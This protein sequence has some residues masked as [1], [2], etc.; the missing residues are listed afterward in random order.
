MATCMADE[1]AY[2]DSED[3]E[4]LIEAMGATCATV[5]P[6]YHIYVYTCT[7]INFTQSNIK[8]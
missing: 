3:D 1:S 8:I 7:N 6:V 5:S 2:T 4:L